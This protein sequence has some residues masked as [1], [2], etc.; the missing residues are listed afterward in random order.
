MREHYLVAEEVL[1]AA[2]KHWMDWNYQSYNYNYPAEAMSGEFMTAAEDFE[3][4]T[5]KPAPA[6]EPIDAAKLIYSL[7]YQSDAHPQYQEHPGY[8][9]YRMAQAMAIKALGWHGTL[10][11]L[12]ETPAWREATWSI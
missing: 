12:K 11:E 8:Q 7:C 9:H 5:F 10:E 6:P 4:F 1:M 3:D 2:V